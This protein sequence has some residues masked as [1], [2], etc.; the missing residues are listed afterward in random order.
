M[1]FCRLSKLPWSKTITCRL[2][3]YHRRSDSDVLPVETENWSSAVVLAI[4][5][6]PC[7]H[8]R[9]QSHYHRDLPYVYIVTRDERRLCT[10]Y[11]YLKH[12]GPSNLTKSFK[13][14]FSFDSADKSV[15]LLLAYEAIFVLQK[16]VVAMWKYF[17]WRLR[18][19]ILIVIQVQLVFFN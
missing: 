9:L 17:D 15:S 19:D 16:C 12:A 18:I 1:V 4:C 13:K 5:A 2:S 14:I 11:C 8:A 7:S 6:R 10:L 3:C